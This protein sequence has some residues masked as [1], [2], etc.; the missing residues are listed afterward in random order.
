AVQRQPVIEPATGRALGEIGL[1]DPAQVARSAAV[2]A[3]AQQ[4]WAAAPYE[5][6][7]RVLRSAARLAEVSSVA[8]PCQEPRTVWRCRWRSMCAVAC[9]PVSS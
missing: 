9:S 3:Q 8:A 6:R 4:A 5:Q 7:A 1:A 2:A